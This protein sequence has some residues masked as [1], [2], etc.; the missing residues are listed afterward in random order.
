M[1]GAPK[2]PP[3]LPMPADATPLQIMIEVERRI[4]AMAA[5][6]NGAADGFNF[7]LSRQGPVAHELA[8]VV[9]VASI[10]SLY[11]KIGSVSFDDK[12]LATVPTSIADAIALLELYDP[13]VATVLAGL[14]TIAEKGGVR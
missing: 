4:D 13:P 12:I 6:I 14:R 3:Y 8:A 5:E 9:D 7:W 11:E 10:Y 2:E 1:S